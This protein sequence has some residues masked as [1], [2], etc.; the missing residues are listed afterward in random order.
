MKLFRPFLVLQAVAFTS[1]NEKLAL[2]IDS[3]FDP[4]D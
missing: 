1:L 2:F 3:T 4:A